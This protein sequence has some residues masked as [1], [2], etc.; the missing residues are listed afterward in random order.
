MTYYHQTVLAICHL[1]MPMPHQAARMIQA[2]QYIDANACGDITLRNMACSACLS[3]FHFNRLFKRCYGQT[4]H[5]YLTAVRIR[6][7]KRLLTEGY[8]V[9]DTAYATGYSSIGSFTSLFK[10]TT[11]YTPASYRQEKQY[12]RSV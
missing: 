8:A 3:L 7:A 10:K 9:A 12:S 5:Q 4:P 6:M 11:G 2:R 1:Y